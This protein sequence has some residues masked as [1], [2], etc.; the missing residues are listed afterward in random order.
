[1]THQFQNQRVL[2]TGGSAG[3]GKAAATAFADE[4]ADVIIVNRSHDSGT[5]AVAEITDRGG[6]AEFHSADLTSS[7]AISELVVATG[8]VDVL[9][10]SA[11][12]RPIP[13]P[14]ADTSE[15]DLDA[16][17]AVNVKAPWLLSAAYGPM[18]AQRRSG[19][20]VHV[21]SVSGTLDQEGFGAYNVSKAALNGLVRAFA[22]ELG[23]TGVRVNAVAPGP[24]YTPYTE[25]FGSALDEL[26]RPYPLGHP[27]TADQVAAA[28]IFLAGST[29]SHITG[30]VLPVDGGQGTVIR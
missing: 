15:D 5:A 22:R 4:G 18:M 11:G 28:I 7:E 25:Q 19:A 27:A 29:A 1:M 24:T 30:A 20:I 12:Y 14:A 2:V 23:P 26:M 8:P 16:T 10:T 6:Q 3:I 13:G 21:S 9:V 17:W